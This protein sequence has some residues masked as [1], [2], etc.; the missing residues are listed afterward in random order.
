MS[1]VGAVSA[2][3]EDLVYSCSTSVKRK[4]ISVIDLNESF[5]LRTRE[6]AVPIPGV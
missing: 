1:K 2:I 5:S 4:I 3:A 6:E